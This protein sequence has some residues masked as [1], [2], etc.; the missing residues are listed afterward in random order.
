[1][2]TSFKEAIKDGLNKMKLRSVGKL[3]EFKK[4]T[5]ELTANKN[6]DNNMAKSML[7]IASIATAIVIYA[8]CKIIG[9]NGML[10]ILA[11]I[12]SQIIILSGLYYWKFKIRALEDKNKTKP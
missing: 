6:K 11:A 8:T 1:M 5:T 3:E 7:S 2:I 4:E 10:A 9:L 12:T